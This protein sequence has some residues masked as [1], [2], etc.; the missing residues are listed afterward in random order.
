MLILQ[1]KDK[2]T[3]ENTQGF[4]QKILDLMNV[5]LTQDIESLPEDMYET[6]VRHEKFGILQKWYNRI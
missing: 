6:A 4:P 3:L 1:D 2:F 5:E